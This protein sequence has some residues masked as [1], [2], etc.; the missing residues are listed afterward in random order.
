LDVQEAIMDSLKE[1]GVLVALTPHQK[2]G[3]LSVLSAQMGTAYDK[4]R[5]ERGQSTANVSFVQRLMKD[6]LDRAG[7]AS[8]SSEPLRPESEV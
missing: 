1:N 6:A 2:T 5:L 8:V 3:L 7:A 4:E